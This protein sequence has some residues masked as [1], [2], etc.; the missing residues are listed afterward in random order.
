[1]NDTINYCFVLVR[2]DGLLVYEDLD[3]PTY[4]VGNCLLSDG[5]L[6]DG[7]LSGRYFAVSR[8]HA[9]VNGLPL[10]M[11]GLTAPNQCI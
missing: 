9:E 7:S 6:I 4:A 2:R 1:M 10:P 8:R 5:A 11:T 3:S